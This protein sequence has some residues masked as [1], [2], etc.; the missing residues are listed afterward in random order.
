M[1]SSRVL[2]ITS[3]LLVLLLTM[4]CGTQRRFPYFGGIEESDQSSSKKSLPPLPDR[5]LSE[6]LKIAQSK[7]VKSATQLRGLPFK[8]DAR[9]I[10][11]SGWEYGTRTREIAE[12]LGGDDLRNLSRLAGAGGMLPEGS[13]LTTLAA[14]FA[15]ASAGATYSPFDK[16]VLLVDK[17]KSDALLAHEFVHALQDQHFDLLKLLAFKPY[18]FDRVEAIFAV[19]EGDAMNVQRRLEYGQSYEQRSLEELA[20]QE[21]ERFNSYRKEVGAMF[22][23]LLTETFIFRYRDGAR[24]VEAMRRRKGTNGVNEIFRRLPQSSE[25]ILHPE[26]YINNESPRDASMSMEKFTEQGWNLITSTS[27]GEIGVRGI[28]GDKLA[29]KDVSKAATGWGGDRA[30]LLENSSKD[31]LFVWKTLWD[32]PKD[33]AEFYQAYNRLRAD[34][35]S[36]TFDERQMRWRESGRMIFVYHKNDAVFILRVPDSSAI[37]SLIDNGDL[38]S[39]YLY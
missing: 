14:S 21:N 18:D 31:R 28:L 17:F 26:K 5:P 15:A 22:P 27:L 29:E 4:A 33:A 23:H 39:K 19:V 7:A 36:M 12:L 34:K 30:F 1:F 32:S 35:R 8:D 16:S 25:Q 10:E 13:D 24:F 11:L 20:K 3:S 38:V 37:Q 6:E 9:M 2:I